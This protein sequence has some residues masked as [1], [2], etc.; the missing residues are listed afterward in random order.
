MKLNKEKT[1]NING[2]RGALSLL[3]ILAICLAGIA[4]SAC[5]AEESGSAADP[6]EEHQVQDGVAKKYV[7]LLTSDKSEYYM[8]IESE[9]KTAGS[10]DVFRDVQTIAQDGS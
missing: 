10:D 6:G 8:T 5:E 3:M 2:K 4:L 1:K 7:D 9:Q